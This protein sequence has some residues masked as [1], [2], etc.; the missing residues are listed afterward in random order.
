MKSSAETRE[1]VKVLT[2]K[3]EAGVKGVFESDKYKAY[4]KAMSKFH[5]YSF[6]NVLLILM[7]CPEASHVAGFSTWKKQFGRT[8]KKGEH[9]IQIIAPTQRS[10]LIKQNRLDPDTQQP[11]IGPDGLP[12][13][14]P[15]FVRR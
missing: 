8:V 7:Q 13:K 9:G 11:I 2:D 14:E 3:L 1:K 12:E 6:G 5:Q 10:R 4:L 15:V